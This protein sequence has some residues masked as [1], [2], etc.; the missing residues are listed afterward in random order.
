MNVLNMR[1]KLRGSVNPSF[2]PQTGHWPSWISGT[3]ARNRRWQFRHSTSGSV[4]PSTW[5]LATHTSGFIRMAASSPSMSSRSWT[6]ER[7]HRLLTLFLSS[8]PS[9]P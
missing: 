3:S 8:T 9:G 2:E 7:H 5:P 4:K 1:L 6:I